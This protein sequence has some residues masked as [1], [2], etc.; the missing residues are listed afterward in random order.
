MHWASS[1]RGCLLGATVPVAIGYPFGASIARKPTHIDRDGH[2]S[3][4][5]AC[6]ASGLERNFNQGPDT[7]A[8][9]PPQ[10]DASMRDLLKFLG[11]AVVFLVFGLAVALFFDEAVPHSAT[12]LG[13]DEMTLMVAAGLAVA[14]MWFNGGVRS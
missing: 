4:V 12:E 1:S 2:A 8:R 6:R 13:A 5:C 14:W 11:V 3:A 9:P 10:G 7:I